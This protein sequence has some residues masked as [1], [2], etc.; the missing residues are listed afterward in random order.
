M[1]QAQGDFWN[2]PTGVIRNRNPAPFRFMRRSNSS[3]RQSPP[4]F[5]HSIKEHFDY[6]LSAKL[7]YHTA[8]Y[9]RNQKNLS[10]NAKKVVL[11]K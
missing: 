11:R 8:T 3:L 9:L 1:R 5:F 10:K 4:F 7:E 2:N 6:F